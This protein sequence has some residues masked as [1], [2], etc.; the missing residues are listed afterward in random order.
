VGLGCRFV[1]HVIPVAA[2]VAKG[3]SQGALSAEISW[4]TA[5][6]STAKTVAVEPVQNGVVTYAGPPLPDPQLLWRIRLLEAG[7]PALVFQSR[8]LRR[9][10]GPPGGVVPTGA[11]S[12]FKT[13]VN[14]AL[15]NE[16]DGAAGVVAARL[17][18]LPRPLQF[19][20]VLLQGDPQGRY[21]ITVRGRVRA[22]LGTRTFSYRRPLRLAPATRP[23]P[24]G[25]VVATPDG[26]ATIRG[27]VLRYARVLDQAIVEAV[28]RQLDVSAAGLAGFELQRA[29]AKFTPTSLRVSSIRVTASATRA[30]ASWTIHAGAITGEGPTTAK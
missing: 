21:V 29:G 10:P 27:P 20:S 13:S 3:Q 23:G 5:N 1:P 11:V 9:L 19:T 7:G 26:P 17:R 22:I 16:I 14:F 8:P 12:L 18:D 24:P 28:E 15:D 30:D 25:V 4:V 2:N 6:G